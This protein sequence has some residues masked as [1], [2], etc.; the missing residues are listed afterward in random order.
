M[1][2]TNIN[3]ES[4]SIAS[5]FD[6]IAHSYDKV[7][8]IL[9]F[10]MDKRW[11]KRLIKYLPKK[12][13]I[14]I[15]DVA[16]GTGDLEIMMAKNCKGAKIRAIDIS[17]NMLEIAKEKA[18]KAK[19]DDKILFQKANVESLPF[20]DNTFEYC[21]ISFGIRNFENINKS[22]TEIYRCLKPGGKL[23]I[24]EF[25]NKPTSKF[26]QFFYKIYSK[27][28][29]PFI[30]GII[31]HNTSAYKYL[32]VSISEF[33]HRRELSR[34]LKHIGFGAVNYKKLTNGIVIF[35]EGVKL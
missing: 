10:N 22:L 4:S 5:M 35:Y 24:L 31:S 23:F 17:E 8:H 18:H 27:I 25:G 11:R 19:V 30:G 32:P 34:Q 28:W 15:L 21:T 20:D 9:S 16:T 14:K 7:N 2:E 13:S 12:H 1:I 6:G 29:I 26:V 3:K 33:V